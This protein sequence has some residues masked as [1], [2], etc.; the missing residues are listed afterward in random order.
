MRCYTRS[1]GNEYDKVAI[2]VFLSYN[3]GMGA[4]GA[5]HHRRLDCGV[6]FGALVLGGRRTTSFQIR[7]LTGLVDE[8]DDRLGLAGIVEGTISKGTEKRSAQD[9]SDAFDAIG[10]QAGSGVGRESIVFR[11]NC[12]PEYVDEALALHAEMLR[13]PTFPTEFCDVAVDLGRQELAALEDDPGELSQKLISSHAYGARLGR[14]E[15]G[16]RECLDRITRED[17]VGFWRDNFTAKRMQVTIGGAVDAERFEARVE[18][19]F[20]GFGRQN[21]NARSRVAVEFSPGVRHHDKKLEQEHILMCWPGVRVT[22]E[23]YPIERV[24][25]E[26]LG[27]GMSSRL[28]TEVREKQGLVY[29]VGAW[30]EHPGGS[31]MFFLGAS[32]TPARCDQTAKTLLREV[33]RLAEDV[34]EEELSRAKVC[35]IAKTKTHGDITRARVSELSRDLFHFGRPVPTSEKNEKVSA[36]T[37]AGIRRYLSEHGREALCVQTLGPRALEATVRGGGGSSQGERS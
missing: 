13:T 33:E 4:D 18:A 7:M 8:P 16:T 19:H 29:W 2:A 23:D 28:F 32:T 6:E 11:C 31:G 35:I 25:L 27:G 26:I 9:L 37:I 5:Y 34:N 15:L 10:A 12:L 36:V 30:N 17:V 22:H 1:F 24:I 20:A 3:A 14:H 21:G